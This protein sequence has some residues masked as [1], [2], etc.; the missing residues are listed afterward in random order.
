MSP[1][2]RALLSVLLYAGLALSLSP[3]IWSLYQ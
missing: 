3:S 2:R 1:R